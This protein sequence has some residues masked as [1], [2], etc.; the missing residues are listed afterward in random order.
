MTRGFW[1]DPERYLDTYWRRIPGRLGARRL[2]LGRRGRLLVPARALRRHAQHRRQ[3]DRAGRARVGGG[4]APGRARGGR[5][6][7]PARG[8]G[9]GRVDLL[10]PAA[11]ATSRRTSSR[12]RSR[13]RSPRELGKAFAPGTGPVRRRA[14][15]D[16]LGEDRAARRPR[17]ARSAPTPATSRRSRT[18]SPSRRSRAQLAERIALVTGGGRGIGAN[19][20]RELA[21]D[22]WSVVV[23]ARTREQ[24]EAVAEE[25]GGRALELD[26]A[27]PRVGRARGR[28]GRRRRAARQ[29]R[30]HRGA[31][32]G[33]VGDRSRRL[34]ARVRGERARRSTSA[35]ARRSRG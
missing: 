24:V 32:R 35:A 2:G 9:R 13:R 14:A 22:G 23:A 12:A 28:G 29:Q 10:L 18:P 19:V 11:R 6:R 21:E 25:I 4:R 3:A 8:E 20:A 26:V 27:S 17:D 15:E 33:D 5:G 16:A 30:G 34:V 31:A 1:R 7:R